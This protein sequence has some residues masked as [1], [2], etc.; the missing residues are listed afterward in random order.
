MF[1]NLDRYVLR[2]ILAPF[3]LALLVFTFILMTPPI[4]Q[5]AQELL[6][7]GVA[8]NI[9]ARALILLVPQALAVTIPM[10]FLLGVLVAFGRLSG[11]SEW[12]A[13]QACGVSLYRMLRPVMLAALL[14]WAGTQWVLLEAVPWSNQAYRELLFKVIATTAESE[15][16]P[17]VFHPLQGTS[18]VMYAGDVRTGVPGWDNVFV[19]DSGQAGQPVIYLARHGRIVV[20]RPKRLVEMILENGVQH[21]SSTDA[22]TGRD[23]YDVNRFNTLI[24]KMDPDRIFTAGP[25]KGEAEM[26]VA[27]L[28]AKVEELRKAGDSPHNALW[29]IQ[30]K[31]SIPVACLVFAMI[32]LGFGVSGART[33]KL[34]AFTVGI[35]VIFAYYIVMYLTLALVKGHKVPASLGPWVPDILLGAFGVFVL[36]TRGRW[37]GHSVRVWLPAPLVNGWMKAR[38]WVER[39]AGST[40]GPAAS[41]D[42]VRKGGRVLVVVRLPRLGLPRPL[43]VDRYIGITYV[44]LLGLTFASLLGIFYI[45]SFI[46]LSEKLFKGKTTFG[47]VMAYLA[48]STPQFVCY[49]IP[50][51]ALLSA[52]IT[53]GILTRNSE[54]IVMKACGI[55]LY[56]IS[57]PLLAFGAAASVVLFGVQ[58]QVLA[59]ANRRA[60]E[61]RQTIRTGTVI[62]PDLLGRR[63][64][65]GKAGEIFHYEFFD[66]RRQLLSSLSIYEFDQK[67]WLLRRRTY[68]ST[69]GFASSVPTANVW[70]GKQGW[71]RELDADGNT[72]SL[73]QYPQRRL[74]LD[75]PSF[76]GSEQPE[77]ERMSFGEL[78]SYIDRM[79]ATGMNV[80]PYLVS[81]HQKIS[82]PFA[83][84]VV[85]LIAVPFA[86]TT[87]RRGALYG[88]GVGIALAMIYWTANN[89]FGALGSAGILPPML[90]AWA[91]NILFGTGAAYLLLTVQT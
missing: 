54:L 21:A 14:A 50:I 81:L 70:I 16:K 48:Y 20:D 38:A 7:K 3:S 6:A 58:E 86:V 71:I 61:L 82:F 53:I 73:V 4:A 36:M 45:A 34:A 44:R 10:A 88:L 40:E 31:F 63:W 84:I 77:A 5:S 12:V 66:P 91:P 22:V 78:R 76:F 85:T 25:T 49:V 15:I 72:S 80:V 65:V 29:F 18:I 17:R 52:L 11:D 46:D 59:Q 23:K 68:F 32:G 51:A 47:M 24:L 55:S 83:T 62:T 75:Q 74:V 67:N 79:G 27:E 60:D 69:A 87:G 1:R 39:R 64:V 90:A 56:R 35:G 43:I 57:L 19:A 42:A 26:T 13:M 89:A 37:G 2:E 41:S 30:Q 28:R 33:G 9:I 8:V